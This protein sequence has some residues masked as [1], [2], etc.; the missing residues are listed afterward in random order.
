MRT[1]LIQSAIIIGIIAALAALSIPL[2]TRFSSSGESAAS[3]QALP[4]ATEAQG[5]A[6]QAAAAPITF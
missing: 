1:L 6:S 4:V 2:V 5:R 3:G